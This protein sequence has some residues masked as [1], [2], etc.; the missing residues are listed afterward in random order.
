MADFQPHLHEIQRG[1][2]AWT[3]PKEVGNVSLQKVD[4]VGKPM[5]VH[6]EVL[7]CNSKVMFINLNLPDRV[8]AVDGSQSSFITTGC[9]DGVLR[10]WN[11]SPPPLPPPTPSVVSPHPV[12]CILWAL[13]SLMQEILSR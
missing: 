4:T 7:V 2:L 13:Q 6:L 1:F 3:V 11:G 12:G 5:L 9:Y 10:F 8:G